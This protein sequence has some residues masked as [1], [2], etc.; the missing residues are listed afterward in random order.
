MLSEEELNKIALSVPDGFNNKDEFH[1]ARPADYVQAGYDYALGILATRPD[2]E[3]VLT[4]D[5][6]K[7]FDYQVPTPDEWKAKPSHLYWERR[8]LLKAQHAKTSAVYAAR[9]ELDKQKAVEAER[10]RLQLWGNEI[11]TTSEHRFYNNQPPIIRKRCDAC[12]Q[13]LREP[14]EKKR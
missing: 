14:Q 11:C 12:W 6:I 4:D 5:E 10:E 3:M 7:H 1:R 8:Y 9:A 2:E 13:S